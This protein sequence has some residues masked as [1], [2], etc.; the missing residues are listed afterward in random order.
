MATIAEIDGLAVPSAFTGLLDT[1]TGAAAAYSV[2]RLSSSATILMRVRRDTTGGTG[3]D[4]EADVAYD[5]N[6]E[7]SLNSA[8]S[9]ASA[10]V[11][12][13]T[14]GEFLNVGTV[15]GTTYSNPDSLT[16]TAIC[17]VDTYT[18][19]SGNGNDLIQN[20]HTTQARLS[21]GAAN[22]DLPK[23]NGKPRL[24]F[25]GTDNLRKLFSSDASQPNTYFTVATNTA[26]V[27]FPKVLFSG[28]T[29]TS[30]RNQTEITSGSVWSMYGGS[31]LTTSTSVD[32]N[33]HLH[34]NLYNSTSSAYYL[35]GSSIGTGD[36]GTFPM[37][38]ITLGA[39]FSETLGWIGNIQEFVFWNS[40]QSSPTNNIPGIESN[41]NG[42]FSIYP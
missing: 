26:T 30:K 2:R 5:S 40:D 41:I 20:T 7:L 12:S 32:T 27:G 9:N 15:G 8:I 31:S 13:T 33:Q 24:N 10:G 19:Q 21:D 3:D 36:A 17:F 23:E 34:T 22:T 11:T 4:D 28:H 38:G 18:D 25:D 29:D 1:Y 37:D 16:T 14:L 39:R 6:D 42:F 35:D